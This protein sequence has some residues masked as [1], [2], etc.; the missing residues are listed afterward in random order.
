MARA[1]LGESF[2]DA[3]KDHKIDLRQWILQGLPEALRPQ[4]KIVSHTFTCKGC[5]GHH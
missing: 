2:G 5:G 1:P 4:Q 3:L